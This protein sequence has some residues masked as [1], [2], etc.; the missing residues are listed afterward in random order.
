MI[1]KSTAVRGGL[2]EGRHPSHNNVFTLRACSR[3]I[4]ATPSH[5]AASAA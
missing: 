4:A 3:A 5:R 1:I 2:S